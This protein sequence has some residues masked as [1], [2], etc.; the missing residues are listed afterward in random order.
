M[1]ISDL[2]VKLLIP[3]QIH[4]LF[5]EFVIGYLSVM[6]IPLSYIIFMV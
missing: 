1:Y 3:S 4:I 5:F 6:L 2:S